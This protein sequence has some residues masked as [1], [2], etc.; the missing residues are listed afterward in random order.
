MST[1]KATFPSL[2]E[3]Q[4]DFI[5][6]SAVL[7]DYPDRGRVEISQ[8]AWPL[9]SVGVDTFEIGVVGDGFDSGPKLPET[10]LLRSSKAIMPEAPAAASP[11]KAA[12][13]EGSSSSRAGMTLFVKPTPFGAV[14]TVTD[15]HSSDTISRVKEK[16][17]EMN[18]VPLNGQRLLFNGQDL[19]DSQTLS[20]YGIQDQTTIQFRR[21]RRL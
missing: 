16:I 12:D 2:R 14:L 7:V 11:P 21:L 13:P 18:G 10:P 5:T 17:K 4:P 20:S 8:E 19:E 1:A 15:L 9:A 3:I 6:F